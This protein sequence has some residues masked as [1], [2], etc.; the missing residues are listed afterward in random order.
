MVSLNAGCTQV[1]QTKTGLDRVTEY[2]HLF[3]GKRI[4]IIANQTAVNS[5]GH[6]I[7]DV[8]SALPGCEVKALYAPEHGLWGAKAAGASIDTVTHPTYGIPVFSLY[9]NDGRMPKPTPDMLN[10]IDVLVFDIQ[11]IGARFYTY[12]WTMALAMEAAAE[13]Q[14]SFVVLDRPNPVAGLAVQGPILDRGF[15]SFVGL[16]PIPVV[17]RMTVGELARLFN[18]QEWSKART[19]TNLSVIPMSGWT[20]ATSFEQ[21]G[22]TFIPP[23]P[24]MRTLDT[25]RVY[26][27]LCLLEGT[28]ISEGRGTDLPFLQFGAPW[29]DAEKLTQR[30][31]D[32]NLPG[33]RFET[34][35]FSPTASKFK[36]KMCHGVRLHI[37]DRTQLQPFALGVHIVR[38]IYNLHGKN[39]QWRESHFDRLCGT[40]QIRLA[41]LGRSPVPQIELTWRAQL[42]AF[43]KLRDRYLHYPQD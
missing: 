13:N 10:N 42:E 33:V 41:I 38:S 23:S 22:L 19:K 34:T 39:F 3:E 11:D 32:L 21:T 24:N 18:G 7:V 36:G 30:L 31:T 8:F 29:L 14:C 15:A 6:S 12:I 17:H 40:D 43:K 37:S 1:A 35:D 16:Y 28:N 9:R 26:P 2:T 5:T 20:H 4:G 25:A 27:G